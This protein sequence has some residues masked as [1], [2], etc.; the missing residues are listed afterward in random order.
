MT[1]ASCAGEA[2]EKIADDLSVVEVSVPA[3]NGGIVG[4]VTQQG[5][6][7]ERASLEQILETF[8]ILEGHAPTLETDLVPNYL[9]SE[10][11]MFDIT[12]E[13]ALVPAPGSGCI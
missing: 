6:S 4:E 11:V 10:S 3:G 7:L 12:A 5:C 2:A 9:R 8:T 1:L 13:G